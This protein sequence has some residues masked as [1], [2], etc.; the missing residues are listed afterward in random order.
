MRNRTANPITEQSPAP[1]EAVFAWPRLWLLVI[2]L[3]L[4]AMAR[5]QQEPAWPMIILAGAST[6]GT[7]LLLRT[8]RLPRIWAACAAGALVAT[9]AIGVQETYTIQTLRTDSAR[10]LEQDRIERATLIAQR[11]TELQQI[12]NEAALSATELAEATGGAAASLTLPA[13]GRTETAVALFENG[14][15]VAHVGQSRVPLDTASIGLSLVKTPF[16]TAMVA[17]LRSNDEKFEAVAVVL[18]AAAAPANR[19]TQSLV[20]DLAGPRANTVD[21]LLPLEA[22]IAP[23]SAERLVRWGAG[24]FARVVAAPRTLGEALAAEK[25]RSRVRTSL[26][27]AVAALF[28]LVIGWRRP[29]RTRER[30]SIVIALLA[31]VALMPLGLLSNRSGIFDPSNYFTPM[32]RWFTANAAALILTASLVLSGLFVVLRSPK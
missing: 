6:V 32:G 21:I 22:G 1:H 15:M 9:V 27:L 29:A 4:C 10:W 24:A 3:A 18:L 20:Q 26:P 14:R 5:W 16:Y 7:V 11:I 25:E 30:L 28:M 17:R 2:V 8:V 13:T 23:D 31:V 19:F 12:L